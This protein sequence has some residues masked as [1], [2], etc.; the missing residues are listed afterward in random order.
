MQK[1]RQEFQHCQVT[2]RRSN[3]YSISESNNMTEWIILETILIS[4][5]FHY[6]TITFSFIST[7]VPFQPLDFC[8]SNVSPSFFT[9]F[10]TNWY[11]NVNQ[12]TWFFSISRMMSHLLHVTLLSSVIC[13]F[14]RTPITIKAARISVTSADFY[15]ITRLRIPEDVSSYSTPWGPEISLRFMYF[16]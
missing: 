15:Q 16:V 12:W 1:L 10:P 7:C 6:M 8:Y 14:H 9:T 4:F 5:H 13:W 3:K 2:K 11:A